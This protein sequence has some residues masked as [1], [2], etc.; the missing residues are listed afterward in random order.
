MSKSNRGTFRLSCFLAWEAQCT[1]NRYCDHHLA[2][3]L[4][5]DHSIIIIIGQPLCPVVVRRPQ[6]AVSKLA[7]LVMSSARS[8]KIIMLYRIRHQLANIPATTYI[9]PCLLALVCLRCRTRSITN[10]RSPCWSV[11][12]CC[13]GITQGQLAVVDDLVSPA[14][15]WA[16]SWAAP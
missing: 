5:G 12:R 14:E 7:C 1:G 10:D 9:T 13:H 8:S 3:Y 15:W 4:F 16:S 2:E 11:L 6:H